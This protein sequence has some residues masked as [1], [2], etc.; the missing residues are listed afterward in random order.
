MNRLNLQADQPYDVMIDK[1]IANLAYQY[2]EQR[3][4]PNG[5]PEVDW[6]RAADDVNRELAGGC[7]GASFATTTAITAEGSL[8]STTRDLSFETANYD[9]KP[10]ELTGE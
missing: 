4:R 1:T 5:S 2:W 8:S 7:A 6:Y 10:E 9:S 3:G